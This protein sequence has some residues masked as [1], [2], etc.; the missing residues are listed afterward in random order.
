MARNAKDRSYCCSRLWL[1]ENSQ[2]FL[3]LSNL[4]CR[5]RYEKQR[6]YEE[7]AT[8]GCD[9][10]EQHSRARPGPSTGSIASI[11]G[12]TPPERKS[13]RG[14]PGNCLTHTHK[15]THTHTQYWLFPLCG[16]SLVSLQLP[17]EEGQLPAGLPTHTLCTIA[18]RNTG[19]R[20]SS[21]S[22]GKLGIATTTWKL[23]GR[24]T[25]LWK[26]QAFISSAPC[27]P[28]HTNTLTNTQTHT[29]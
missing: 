18:T 12:C 26:L 25:D 11:P 21:T 23:Q 3:K 5:E 20:F 1:Y 9:A 27:S 13:M 17:V 19:S 4:S 7:L 15:H 16:V 29:E 24:K 10:Q 6:S 14:T 2:V 22:S 28:T 8:P